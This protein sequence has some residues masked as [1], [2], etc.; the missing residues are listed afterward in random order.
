MRIQ[1]TLISMATAVKHSLA[2]I[3]RKVALSNLTAKQIPKAKLA[4]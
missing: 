2:T 3:L 4:D 1:V